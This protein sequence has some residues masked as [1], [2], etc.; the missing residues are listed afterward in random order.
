MTVVLIKL[1]LSIELLDYHVSFIVTSNLFGF[2]LL[3][4]H[5]FSNARSSPVT[6]FHQHGPIVDEPIIIEH[7][8]AYNI[9][10]PGL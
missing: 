2:L 6:Y 4:N 5:N 10:S 1:L 8:L 9:Y 3:N 7:I